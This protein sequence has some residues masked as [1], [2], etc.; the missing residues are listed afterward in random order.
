MTALRR[1]YVFGLIFIGVGI[2][3][4]VIGDFLEMSLYACGGLAFIVNAL[5]LEP[6]LASNKK[7][8]VI[9]SWILI[10]TTGLLFLYLIQFKFLH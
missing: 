1:Q 9:L 6:K 10:I 4:F 5:T 2:Y 8:L 3:Q 7:S